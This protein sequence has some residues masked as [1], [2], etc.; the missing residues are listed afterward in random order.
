MLTIL[1][2][3]FTFCNSIN[4]NPP[5]IIDTLYAVDSMSGTIGYHIEQNIYMGGVCPPT[6]NFLY[7][8]DSV[9]QFTDCNVSSRSFISFIIE[10]APV[11]YHIEQVSLNLYQWICFGNGASWVYPVFYDNPN[12]PCLIAQVNYESTLEQSD[13]NSPIITE[14]GTISN[15]NICNWKHLD[16]TNAYR[17]AE[18]SSLQYFQIMVYF[19]ILSDFDYF[20]DELVFNNAHSAYTDKRL[21]IDIVYKSD[22]GCVDYVNN[23]SDLTIYPNPARNEISLK[24]SNRGRV[25]ELEIFNIKGQKVSGEK[26]KYKT[27]NE[28]SIELS[29]NRFHPGVY[30]IKCTIS[31]AQNSTFVLKRFVLL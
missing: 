30:F 10:S 21:N 19:N 31:S 23:S 26:T 25:I 5:E 4:A 7:V 22:V 14:I 29:P 9:D 24:F 18:L 15:N 1:F 20:S 8:G 12:Y 17:N 11:N 13:F 27:P 28:Y 16:I 2:S 6:E 3:L